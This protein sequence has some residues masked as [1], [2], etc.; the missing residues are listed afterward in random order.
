VSLRVAVVGSRDLKVK[1][2]GA[3]LPEGTTEIISGGARG[4]D[5]FAK[6]YARVHGMKLTEFR[7]DYGRYKKA[8]PLIRNRAIVEA[9]DWVL[10][11]WDGQSHGTMHTINLARQLGKPVEVIT[12]AQDGREE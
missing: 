6:D 3:Y 10:A 8:A 7:P 9:A 4:I 12:I 1:D 5:T 2:L 11:L